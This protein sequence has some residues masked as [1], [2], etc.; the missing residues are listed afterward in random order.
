M[1]HSLPRAASAFLLA[2][3]LGACAQQPPRPSVIESSGVNASASA[4]LT[5]LDSPSPDQSPDLQ[6]TNICEDLT[7]GYRVTFPGNWETNQPSAFVPA[8]RAFSDVGEFGI[9][10]EIPA[11]VRVW[12]LLQPGDRLNTP[13]GMV[14]ERNLTVG[15]QPGIRWE[16]TDATEPGV[17]PVSIVL[18]VVDL[19]T[20]VGGGDWLVAAT[21]SGQ[22]GAYETN[23]AVLDWMMEH[24]EF[25]TDAN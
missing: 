10:D 13:P 23:V 2:A 5:G 14:S 6:V 3:T 15:N 12:F 17:A 19:P 22:T 20:S 21:A 8:C 9:P 11:Y 7:V 1:G 16:I 24:L 18:Y 4:S 25:V